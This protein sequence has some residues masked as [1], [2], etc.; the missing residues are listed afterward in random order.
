MEYKSWKM[1]LAPLI[2]HFMD[3]KLGS[4]GYCILWIRIHV[5]KSCCQSTEHAPALL[6]CCT[7]VDISLIFHPGPSLVASS[8][9]LDI[10]SVTSHNLLFA[11]VKYQSG[12]WAQDKVLNWK[13]HSIELKVERAHHAQPMALAGYNA[14]S[15][16]CATKYNYPKWP[17]VKRFH[18]IQVCCVQVCHQQSGVQC[19]IINLSLASGFRTL[20]KI[21]WFY[22]VLLAIKSS[23]AKNEINHRHLHFP[24]IRISFVLFCDLIRV[25]SSINETWT[26]DIWEREM[27]SYV[28][29]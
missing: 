27:N 28:E 7:L 9:Y 21:S 16:F 4:I 19:N 5:M 12:K 13:S 14:A 23:T 22:L 8:R 18:I 1:H 2:G 11:G 10:Y 20:A 17:R 3:R 29:T 6:C 15:R 25:L 24:S 26:R